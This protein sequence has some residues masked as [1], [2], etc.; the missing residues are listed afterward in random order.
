MPAVVGTQSSTRAL[1]V[2]PAAIAKQMTC[3]GRLVDI[4][5]QGSMLEM[6]VFISLQASA[7]GGFLRAADCPEQGRQ[8]GQQFPEF[9]T[10]GIRRA[11]WRGVKSHVILT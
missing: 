2:S 7:R 8:L 9:E 1:L 3:P 10:L 11:I 5:S 4:G 6:P